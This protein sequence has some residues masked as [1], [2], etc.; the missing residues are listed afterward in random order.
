MENTE[1]KSIGEIIQSLVEKFGKELYLPENELRFKGLLFDF[2]SDFAKELKILK[3]AIAERIPSK[4]LSCDGKDDEEKLR[5]MQLCKTY[6]VDEIGLMEDRVVQ[7]LN[8][9]AEGLE[10]EM[11]LKEEQIEKPSKTTEKKV[12]VESETIEKKEIDYRELVKQKLGA[13]PLYRTKRKLN[14]WSNHPEFSDTVN[15]G[16]SKDIDAEKFSDELKKRFY[17]HD[18]LILNDE[19]NLFIDKYLRKVPLLSGYL[20][21][22]IGGTAAGYWPGSG[23]DF[24]F[25]ALILLEK[26]YPMS[27]KL[28]GGFQDNYI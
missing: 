24:A 6:L 17:F 5:T 16:H 19:L 10:W 1:K 2:A 12:P 21:L 9:L 25:C 20:Y 14:F 15:V 23:F 7:V 3:V 13:F 22:M 8:V 18:D 11:R 27:Y 4:F 26:S 28:V